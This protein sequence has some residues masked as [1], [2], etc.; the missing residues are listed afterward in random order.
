MDHN[1]VRAV[2]DKLGDALDDE[3]VTQREGLLMI[4]S[5]NHVSRAVMDAQGS[6]LTN[7]NALGYPDDRLYPASWNIDRVEQLAIDHATDLWGVDHANVQPHSGRSQT[8]PYSTRATPSSRS[9][10]ATSGLRLGTPPLTS[11]G[12]DEADLRV[13]GDLIGRVL[14]GED[15]DTV[16]ADVQAFAATRPLYN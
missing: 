6:V 12:F 8:S 1:H 14:D 7:R 10:H 11:R 3:A 13:V 5:E 4:A 16:R 9:I 2:S 15:P